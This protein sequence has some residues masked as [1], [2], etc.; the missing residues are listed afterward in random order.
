MGKTNNKLDS[1]YKEILDLE[2]KIPKLVIKL[3]LEAERQ[4]KG[5]VKFKQTQEYDDNNYYTDTNIESIDGVYF[6]S[7]YV[8]N[9][10]DEKKLQLELDKVTSEK[11]KVKELLHLKE[12][13]EDEDGQFY[14]VFNYCITNNLT[15]EQFLHAFVILDAIK[16]NKLPEDRINYD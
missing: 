10:L 8:L 1:I 9:E 13:N 3:F 6:D 16:D 14:A 15:A 5:E 12:E 4:L 2:S 7:Y 11:K